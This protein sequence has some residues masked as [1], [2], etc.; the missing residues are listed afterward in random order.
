MAYIC[1]QITLTLSSPTV[2]FTAQLFGV[3]PV[4]GIFNTNMRSV[5]FR[6]LHPKTLLAIVVIGGASIECSLWLYYNAVVVGRLGV[7]NAAGII[8]LG[9]I[10][11]G[12]LQLLR[13]AHAWPHLIRLWT[14]CETVF[15]RPPYT[16]VPGAHRLRWR[17]RCIT[18]GM[19][20]LAMFE[21]LMYVGSAVNN[22]RLYIEQC[23]SPNVSLVEYVLQRERPHIM[24]M[25]PYSV[26]LLVVPIE[27]LN[28]A[29]TFCWSFVD[30][31]IMAV[32]LGLARRFDQIG[33]RLESTSGRTMPESYWREMRIQY[34]AMVDLVQ[35]VDAQTSGL[36]LQSCA[37][38]L[39]FVCF[40]LFNSFR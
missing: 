1:N 13:V 25:W 39:F 20:F 10:L 18:L 32:S 40:Q 2:L 24:W 27:Y 35:R 38:N 6:W 34:L 5:R 31:W 23:G 30:V 28:V 16:P 9:S 37:S 11:C 33:E 36:V 19:L 29:M 17:V 26:W 22:A 4:A 14:R 8:F 7:S 12:Q 3:L 15:L 21:H